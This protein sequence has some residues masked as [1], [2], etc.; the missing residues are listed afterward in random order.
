MRWRVVDRLHFLL[1]QGNPARPVPIPTKRNRRGAMLV[2]AWVC[3]L[4]QI[5]KDVANNHIVFSYRVNKALP[6]VN[7]PG[8]VGPEEFSAALR[9]GGWEAAKQLHAELRPTVSANFPA[10]LAK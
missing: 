7:K 10:S 8:G 6:V 2:P 3:D 9:L 1:M 5:S 4:W